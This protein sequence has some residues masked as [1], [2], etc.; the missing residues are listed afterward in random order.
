MRQL[1]LSIF[2]TAFAFTSVAAHK[3]KTPFDDCI[4]SLDN[5][6]AVSGSVSSLTTKEQAGLI[7]IGS[8]AKNLILKGKQNDALVKLYDYQAKLNN[9][10]ATLANP[11]PKISASDEQLLRTALNE[12]I[13]CLSGS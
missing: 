5:L 7:K 6:I 10:A 12:A 8:D 11:V 2:V 9:L 3:D 4:P 1:F 13:A